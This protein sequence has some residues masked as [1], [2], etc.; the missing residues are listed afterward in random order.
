MTDTKGPRRTTSVARVTCHKS[1]TPNR[2]LVRYGTPSSFD[3]LGTITKVCDGAWTAEDRDGNRLG[4]T[5]KKR[6]AL[7]MVLAC[8]GATS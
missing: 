1:V 2:L 5:N 6:Y 3:F 7:A 8:R 4:M